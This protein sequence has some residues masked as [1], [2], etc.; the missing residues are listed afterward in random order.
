MFYDGGKL[1]GPAI[2]WYQCIIK[3]TPQALTL[4]SMTPL[5]SNRQHLAIPPLP[6]V[7]NGQRKTQFI[8]VL[9][10]ATSSASPV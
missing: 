9:A 6:L 8:S 7:S 4:S 10:L 1:Y 2:Q 5:V 3:V